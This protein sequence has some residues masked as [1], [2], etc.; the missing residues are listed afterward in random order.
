MRDP[1]A[2][3]LDVGAPCAAAVTDAPLVVESLPVNVHT[4]SSTRYW[5]LISSHAMVDVFPVM[6]ATLLWPLRERL[7]LT[8]GQLTFVMMATPIFSGLCQPL[9]AWLTDKYNTRLCGPVGLAIG[10]MCIGSIG[11]VQTFWQLAALQ[12]VGVIAIGFYHPISAALAGQV[13]S[14]RLRN[15]RTQAI[16]VFISSGMVGHALGAKLGPTI[17]AL[18]DGRGMP[19]LAWLII[20]ALLLALGLHFATRKISHRHDNHREIHASFLP[21]VSKS[22][23]WVIGILTVQNALRF[24]VNVGL[25]VVMLNVWAR[26]KLLQSGAFS[27]EAFGSHEAMER[28]LSSQ[29]S[30]HAGSL[31]AAMT[32]GMG[33]CAIF[34]GR[35]VKRGKEW[36]PLIVLSLIGAV[37][38][39]MLGP[40][41]DAMYSI[42]GFAWWAMTPVYLCTAC[43]AIGFFATFPIATSLAQ[44]LQP[45]H[46][47]LVTSMMM[48]VGWG[49]SAVAPLLAM[50]FFGFVSIDAAPTLSPA[51]INI[52]FVCFAGLL[53]LAG[54]LTLVIPR[55]LVRNAAEQH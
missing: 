33:L 49:I 16:G 36:W 4:V 13:G 34:S 26:S 9:F 53:V 51:R 11:F 31:I 25:M 14:T 48:G 55:D 44:R 50:V 28:A 18:N 41:A 52:A 27:I 8:P 20:P 7:S 42:G 23:W 6:F 15:G 2:T 30:V 29:A 35:L 5:T 39:A 32:V 38:I 12:I 40:I 22:H 17:N 43:T 45:G 1:S 47:S 10:A 3:V 54:L 37:V 46:T 19:Y 21:G 24:T